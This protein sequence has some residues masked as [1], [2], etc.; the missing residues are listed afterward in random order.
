VGLSPGPGSVLVG[1]GGGLLGGGLVLV[2]VG[3]GFG[4][5]PALQ[6]TLVP[7][8]V[9]PRITAARARSSRGVATVEG[10]LLLAA[11]GGG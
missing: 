1:L 10:G 3:P 6:A 5:F 11:S 4:G 7:L 2:Q 8:T 9:L